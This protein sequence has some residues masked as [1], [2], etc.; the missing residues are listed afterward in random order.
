MGADTKIEWCD[1]TFNPW[2]GCTQV[3]PGCLN[4][5]AMTLMARRYGRVKWGPG[6][7]RARTSKAYWRQ[8]LRWNRLAEE[9]LSAHNREL[10]TSFGH[11]SEMMEYHPPRVFCASLADWLDWDH[12]PVQW[13]VELLNLIEATPAL[14]W[15]LLTKRPESWSARMHEAMAAGSKL[16]L[17]WLNGEAPANVWVGTTVEDQTRADERIPLLLEIPARVRFLSCEPLLGEVKLPLRCARDHNAD[18][19][20]DRH[21]TGCPRIHWVIIGGESGPGARDFNVEAA[22]DLV[23]QCESAGVATFVKQLGARPVTTNANVLDWP[24]DTVFIEHAEGAGSLAGARVKLR[25]A[26]GGDFDEFPAELQIREFPE[27][28][29]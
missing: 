14:D 17:R 5:Y 12:V 23:M 16:A 13:R 6:Q 26:K 9:Q 10:A 20:C 25:S 4:C 3:S 27:V 7:A 15:L 2:I 29:S 24:D 18:G 1:Y 8:P 28:A 11:L 22:W 19:D 21:P